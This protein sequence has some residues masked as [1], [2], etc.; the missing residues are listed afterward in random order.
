[1]L[2]FF[3][4]PSATPLLFESKQ[5]LYSITWKISNALHG[6]KDKTHET[7]FKSWALNTCIHA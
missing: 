4:T 6:C 1:M 2:V 5:F 7:K 3:F